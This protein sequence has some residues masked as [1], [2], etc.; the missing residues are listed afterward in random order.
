V[1]QVEVIMGRLLRL[2][3]ISG[4]SQVTT[5]DNCHA[6]DIWTTSLPTVQT[7]FCLLTCCCHFGT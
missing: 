1:K 7:T 3:M 4:Y 6:T 2:T 5:V